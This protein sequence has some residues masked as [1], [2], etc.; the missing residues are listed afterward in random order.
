MLF[1]KNFKS[2]KNWWVLHLMLKMKKLTIEKIYKLEK[3]CW[4]LIKDFWFLDFMLKC[5]RENSEKSIHSKNNN[6]DVKNIAIFKKI[7]NKNMKINKIVQI[8]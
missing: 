5:L 8:E 3:K 2:K 4:K 6:F 7:I 1:L